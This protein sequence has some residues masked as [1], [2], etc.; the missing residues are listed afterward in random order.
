ML[1]VLCYFVDDVTDLACGQGL[2]GLTANPGRRIDTEVTHEVVVLR[3]ND[4]VGVTGVP[5]DSLVRGPESEIVD[6]AESLDVVPERSQIGDRRPLDVL[7][8]EEP[9]RHSSCAPSGSV[10]RW[11]WRSTT[12]SRCRSTARI[13]A[14]WS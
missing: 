9:I 1:N 5:G 7:V 3:E 14:G 4:A 10:V 8:G 13:S 12:A 11:A 2:V 6:C